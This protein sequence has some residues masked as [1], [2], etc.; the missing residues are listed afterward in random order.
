MHNP[1]I[2]KILK[3]KYIFHKIHS[4]PLQYAKECDII[5]YISF[6]EEEK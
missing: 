4:F 3:I 1:V 2:A 5:L 6:L